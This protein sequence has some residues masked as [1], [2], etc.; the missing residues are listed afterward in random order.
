MVRNGLLKKHG[1]C[2]IMKYWFKGAFCGN[3]LGWV[4]DL[5]LQEKEEEKWAVPVLTCLTV[6]VFERRPHGTDCIIWPGQGGMGWPESD[7]VYSQEWKARKG[8]TEASKFYLKEFV[9]KRTVEMMSPQGCAESDR[10][11]KLPSFRELGDGARQ[12]H[13]RTH[14]CFHLPEIIR[15]CS[16][17]FSKALGKE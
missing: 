1:I 7:W 11:P 3:H 14:A 6:T 2:E 12:V 4:D 16:G 9:F 17:S 15:L 8:G 10:M 5:L 13:N